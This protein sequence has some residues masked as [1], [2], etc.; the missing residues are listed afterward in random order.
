[1]SK[2]CLRHDG[3]GNKSAAFLVAIL[4]ILGAALAGPA[5][6]EI[7]VGLAAPL[8][9]RMA[10]V[11]LAMQR[12]LETAVAE[13]NAAGGVLGQRL[14]LA[15]EDDGCGGATAQGAASALLSDKPA[16]VVGHPCSGAAIA[17][18]PLYRTAGV[19]L[20][21]V[22]ARHPD[23]TR[24]GASAL[25]LRLAGRDDRQGAAAARWLLA[26]APARRIAVLH[27]RT[28]YASR[29]ADDAVA[30]LKAAG[31]ETV[32][33]LPIVAGKPDYE[34]TVLRLKEER[35]E[36]VFFAGYPQEA[37]IVVSALAALGLDIPVL[38]SDTLATPELARSA[39]QLK[40]RIEVLLPAEPAPAGRGPV[41]LEQDGATAAGARARGAFE[42]WLAKAGQLGS[43]DGAALAQA[44][45]GTPVRTPALGEI[46][47]DQNGD[48]DAPGFAAASARGDG[49]LRTN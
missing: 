1:M 34:A 23:V 43:L 33:V 11:G 27:D 8:S 28:G 21:A 36:A 39:D 5:S 48:L 16:L 46:S 17:A 13:A 18:L 14:V 19:L 35:A 12:A 2:T 32:S 26:R 31:V 25:V 42:A 10:P 29:L 30:A 15:T 6:A 47:F 3:G 41:P 22:G 37:A 9:G 24:S 40:A 38:G 49:W 20:I 45:K 4:V 44:L 7:R